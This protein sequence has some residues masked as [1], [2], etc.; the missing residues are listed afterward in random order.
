M[1]KIMLRRFVMFA[2]AC[3]V[4]IQISGSRLEKN[5]TIGMKYAQKL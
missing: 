1:M 4:E 2:T 3:M 5:V